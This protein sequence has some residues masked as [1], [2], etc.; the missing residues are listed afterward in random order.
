MAG[1]ML[2]ENNPNIT[3]LNDPNR[4]TKLA[5]KWCKIYD[6]EWTDALE[7]LE[8]KYSKK[9]HEQ[10]VHHLFSLVKVSF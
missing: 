3:D 10:Y 8:K 2:T 9:N 1:S 6:D 7:S 4:A 5:E